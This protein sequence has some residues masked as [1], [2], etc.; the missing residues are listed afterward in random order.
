MDPWRSAEAAP[1]FSSRASPTIWANGGHDGE[2]AKGDET[3]CSGG[4]SRFRRAAILPDPGV[5]TF[6]P[7]CPV[8]PKRRFGDRLAKNQIKLNKSMILD[9]IGGRI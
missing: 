7:E 4:G 6:S 2:V 9:S 8:R 5:R 1:A 3:A